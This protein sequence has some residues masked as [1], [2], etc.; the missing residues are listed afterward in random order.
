MHRDINCGKAFYKIIKEAASFFSPALGYMKFQPQWLQNNYSFLLRR[1]SYK[2]KKDQMKFQEYAKTIPHKDTLRT[3]LHLC[4]VTSLSRVLQLKSPQMSKQNT[5][6]KSINLLEVLA[7]I[8]PKKTI[9]N[10][11][12]PVNTIR[13]NGSPCLTI[14]KHYCVKL[15]FCVQ[16]HRPLLKIY[17]DI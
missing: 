10:L 2:P 4:L 5:K 16:K 14:S 12:A 11:N 6:F 3:D 7:R 8:P 9:L 17:G 1:F 13:L 15:L